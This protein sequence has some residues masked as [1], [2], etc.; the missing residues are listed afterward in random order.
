VIASSSARVG[1]SEPAVLIDVPTFLV[2]ALLGAALLAL[3]VVARFPERG[4]RS[5]RTTA[6]LSVLAVGAMRFLPL[7]IPGAL[8]LPYGAYAALLGLVLPLFF[9]AFL[10]AAWL[11]RALAS[12][13]GGS[14]EGG[15]PVEH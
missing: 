8:K 15:L 9:A 13:L 7:V 10:S 5:L 14:G 11:M 12:A 6:G 4:P 2:F 3:W 1:G